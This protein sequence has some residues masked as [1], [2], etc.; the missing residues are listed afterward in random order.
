MLNVSTKDGN[1]LV[2][3]GPISAPAEAHHGPLL[4]SCLVE[5]SD[6]HKCLQCWWQNVDLVWNSDQKHHTV[7]RLV[8]LDP[9]VTP[10]HF[11][12]VC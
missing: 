6:L 10:S 7:V 1:C 2:G 5:Q 4:T 3:L 8:R 11:N 12:P 9:G